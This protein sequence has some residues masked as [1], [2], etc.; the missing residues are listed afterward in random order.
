MQQPLVCPEYTQAHRAVQ[1]GGHTAVNRLADAGSWK[2]F[3]RDCP[4]AGSA[5]IIGAMMYG[6]F[7]T[8]TR[9]QSIPTGRQG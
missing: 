4:G 1:R 3:P 5:G 8:T 6:Q 7:G 9:G 2:L